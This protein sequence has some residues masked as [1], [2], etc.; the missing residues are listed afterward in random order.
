NVVLV[1]YRNAVKRIT[2]ER[3]RTLVAADFGIDLRRRVACYGYRFRARIE[4]HCDANLRSR[5]CANSHVGLRVSEP[6]SLNQNTVFAGVHIIEAK[7]A[8]IV[9]DTLG[10]RAPL[11]LHECELCSGDDRA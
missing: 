1:E 2:V 6:N 4:R 7:R 3:G 8:S 11:V 5:S 10:D 9:G